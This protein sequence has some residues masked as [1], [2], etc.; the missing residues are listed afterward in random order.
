MWVVALLAI[1][2]LFIPRSTSMKADFTF[3][4]CVHI[5]ISPL[6]EGGL[7]MDPDDKGNW[8]GGK[9]GLGV[10]K[11]TN[12]GISAA[13]Y[14]NEDIKNMSKARAIELYKR[15]YWDPVM[16]HI[17]TMTHLKL[18][19]FD[20]AVNQ[21]V[22]VAI[23]LLQSVAAVGGDEAQILAFAQLRLDRYAKTIGADKYLKGW[24]N[25]TNYITR[26]SKENLA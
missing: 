19:A 2:V 17:G 13:A 9:V 20:C 23:K 21:G 15:D 18:M 14:P 7:S 11:G 16:K 26:L 25:R 3:D 1:G 10:L 5:V 6:V 24:T 8:T 22:S 4:Y 12:H